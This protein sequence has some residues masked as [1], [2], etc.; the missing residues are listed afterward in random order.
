MVC[1]KTVDAHDALRKSLRLDKYIAHK[2]NIRLTHAHNC[3]KVGRYLTV[4]TCDGIEGDAR[5]FIER[6]LL[7]TFD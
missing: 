5:N 6:Q 4:K 1:Y 3:T 7:K 2:N